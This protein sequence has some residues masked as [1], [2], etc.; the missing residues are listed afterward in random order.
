MTHTRFLDHIS[1]IVETYFAVR[2]RPGLKPR[3][4][5]A[6]LFPRG[7]KT[8]LP[9]INAGASTMA[10]IQPFI[11]YA[12]LVG[13]VAI[14]GCGK[15]ESATAQHDAPSSHETVQTAQVQFRT[16]SPEF[17]IPASVQPDP[18]RVVH[19]F[20]PVSGRLV[21]L[22]VKLGDQVRA[23][24]SIATVQSSDA[25]SALSDYEKAKAQADRSQ[26]ALRR[27]TVL[28]EHEV[29]ATKDM[30]DAKAQ[31]ASDQSDLARSRERLQLLGLNEQK[32]SDKVSVVTPRSGVVTE[33]T[34]APGE[35]SKSLDASNPLATIA[36]LSSVW[37]VGNVYERD[38]ALVPS[39]APVRITIDAYPTEIWKGTVSKV[40]DIVD[41]ATR[42]VKVRVV[43]NNAVRKLKPD[44]FA[45]IHLSRP[46]T[47]MAVI[48]STAL[49]HEQNEAFVILQTAPGKF[50]RR[51]VEV[52]QTSPQET[53]VRAGLQPGDVVVTSGAELLRE[54]A[55]R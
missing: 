51:V 54:E 31:A 36:D 29:I 8:T 10:V 16:V 11:T 55:S 44:M 40:G 27:A 12:L 7:L 50:T 15:D 24:Q 6:L 19:V 5:R 35:F 33:T 22:N 38:L 46:G 49:L 23:G 3:Y 28:Y 52:E 21:S 34:S 1:R 39:N 37:I 32:Q 43:L 17:T 41:P 47:R 9:R 48:P 13:V 53:L 20:A 26:S 42:T 4:F 18:V 14:A 2:K 45:T 30:E 25:A